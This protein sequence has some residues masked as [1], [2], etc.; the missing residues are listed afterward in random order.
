MEDRDIPEC[1]SDGISGT[2]FDSVESDRRVAALT[3]TG[4][5]R[6]LSVVNMGCRKR[7]CRLGAVLAFD[8]TPSYPRVLYLTAKKGTGAVFAQGLVL[9]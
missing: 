4:V 9:D 1:V 2:I 8:S 5:S 7:F 6:Q 3:P